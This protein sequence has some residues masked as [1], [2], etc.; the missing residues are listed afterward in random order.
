MAQL[1]QINHLKIV[2]KVDFGFYLDG[3]NLGEILM[4]KRY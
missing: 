3:E 4:P 2:R 1:G